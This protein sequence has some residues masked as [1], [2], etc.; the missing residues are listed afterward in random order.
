MYYLFFFNDTATTEIYTLSLHDAL[1][2][3]RGAI[4]VRILCTLKKM[5]ITS[6]VI[7]ADDDAD[8]LHVLQADE[9]Y[10]LGSG[11]ATDTYL[12]QDKLFV[13]I[14]QSGAEAVHP[15][16]GFLSENAEFVRRCENE[17]VI[18]IG[19]T[20]EQMQA[21]GLKH[22]ARRLAQEN[23]VPLLPGSE[24][25]D[26]LTEAQTAALS[27][28]Y[29]VMLKSTAGGG[30]IGMQLCHSV[31]DLDQAFDSVRRL[32]ENN[33][34]NSGVF[35]EKFISRARHIEVQVFGDGHGNAV[36]LGERDCS[37]QRR[38]QKVIEETPAPNLSAGMRTALHHTAARLLSAIQYRNAGTV[39]FVYDQDAEKFYFLE[40]NTRLQV[41]HGIT[42]MVF[43]VDLVEW[44]IKLAAGELPALNKLPRARSPQGHSIQV[45]LYAEDP[46]KNF[47]PSAGLITE[48]NFP[49][50]MGLRI[51]TWIET[52]IEV[53]SQYDPML[54]KIIATA[55]S[56]DEAI[57]SLDKALSKT[58]VHGIETNR[59]YV[60]SVLQTDIFQQG[61]ISTRFLNSYK[62]TPD[63]LDIISAGTMTT[64][65]DYPGRRGYW[66][67]GIPPSGPFDAYAFRL[68]NRL[69]GND[70]DA[71]G[72]EMTDRK[73]TRLNSSHTDISRMPSSA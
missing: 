34:S 47:Q 60:R 52:G 18:F 51:D 55:D 41:E 64:I 29:P 4:A 35:L 43:G 63:S 26:S 37:S 10:S 46:N 40:V 27:I 58:H 68:G 3:Y 32:S 36:A 22:E 25:L 62:Y 14:K 24:L 7:Y 45:R 61:Q 53:S 54:A 56:R 9:A 33:F 49:E 11:R 20:I 69:L 48:V 39:E 28:G 57:T 1:P 16:Y 66:D 42:E 71:A 31:D 17:G 30:G 44:M 65:Q 38:N 5:N 8:S 73:S 21:F 72:L 59:D 70:S 50:T 23:A 67:V 6:V 19:P 12:N 13:I 15:G 2:I